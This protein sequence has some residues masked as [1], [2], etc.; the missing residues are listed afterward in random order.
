M[1]ELDGFVPVRLNAEEALD[2]LVDFR[3]LPNWDPGIESAAKLDDGEVRI[4]SRFDVVAVFLSR[5]VPMQYRV[6]ELDRTRLHAV[7]VG[8]SLT[9]RATDRIAVTPRELGSDV[10]W[11]AELEFR[12]PLALGETMMR[13]LMKRLGRKAMNGMRE[14]L[15]R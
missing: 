14:T 3:N 9:V 4:G 13:P 7:L 15:G 6:V 11:R 5:R 10:T 12:G 2:Y 1:I 8:N